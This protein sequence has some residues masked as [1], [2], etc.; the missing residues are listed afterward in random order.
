MRMNKQS[1]KAGNKRF[2]VSTALILMLGLTVLPCTNAVLAD[3]SSWQDTY[4]AAQASANGAASANTSNTISVENSINSSTN[5]AT[6]PKVTEG[7]FT[8]SA[9]QDYGVYSENLNNIFIIF[10][11]VANAGITDQPVYL[12]IPA[13]VNYTASK[14][15]T[16]FDYTSR[17]FLTADGTYVFRFTA[18]DDA[19][20]PVSQQT[21]YK[22]VFYFR[23]QAKLPQASAASAAAAAGTA[24]SASAG[25]ST[26][27][28]SAGADTKV[29]YPDGSSQSIT[30]SIAAVI[31]AANG[32]A[33][34]SS[35]Q[36]QNNATEAAPEE[37][38]YAVETA[39]ETAEE[40]AAEET[41]EETAA[42]GVTETA[43]ETA[44]EETAED[45][46]GQP[47]ADNGYTQSY[48]TAN[49]RFE[50]KLKDGTSFLST[51]PNG[52]L[53]GY[54]VSLDLTGLGDNLKETKLLHDGEDIG[55]TETIDLN[56]PGSYELLIPDSGRTDTFSFF[57]PASKT[58]M[59]DYY[60]VPDGIKVT[61][62]TKNGEAVPGAEM[63]TQLDFTE[64]ADYAVSLADA[65]GNLYEVN[66]ATDHT[67]PEFSIAI[68]NHAAQ[69]TYASDDIASVTLINEKGEATDYTSEV[70]SITNPGH[71]KIS[72][73]DTSGN[74]SAEQSFTVTKAFNPAGIIAILIV[75]ALVT[76]GILF[77]RKTKQNVKIK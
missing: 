77:Y 11:T 28:T 15:G 20:L 53:Y 35:G 10:T 49:S 18:T 61:S 48:D 67:A 72:A 26:A 54:A 41:A 62:F 23:K 75:I 32:N 5:T 16:K 58:N 70:T 14:D 69:I 7:T 51:V 50:I 63:A 40:T 31:N 25:S 13:G 64:D 42:A 24:A 36:A 68:V 45:M 43:D 55:A 4:N 56:E 66:F 73:K 8:E 44:P 17:Q 71:Y 29:F 21:V 47:A 38:A 57:M 52:M 6:G 76:A 12:D 34:G 37:T 74:V 39:E 9:Y 60:T 3:T 22:A 46:T 19:S 59:L 30:E 65:Y 27:G 33:S 2:M 1:G